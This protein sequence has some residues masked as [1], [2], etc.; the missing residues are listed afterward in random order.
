M[1]RLKIGVGDRMIWR[2]CVL[3]CVGFGKVIL[4]YA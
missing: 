2:G 4:R 1:A 3:I